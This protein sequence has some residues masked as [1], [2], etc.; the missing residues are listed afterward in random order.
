MRKLNLG[1]GCDY[2]EGFINLDINKEVKADI[3][4][5][6]NKGLPFKDNYFDYIFSCHAIEH[7]KD[8]FGVMD[9][10][11]RVCKDKAIIEIYVP[12]FTSILAMKYTQHNFYFGIDSFISMAEE[13]DRSKERYNKARFKILKQ[14]LHLIHNSVSHTSKRYVKYFRIL[15]VFNPLF[16][17]CWLWQLIMERVFFIG[18]D[19]IYYKLEVIKNQ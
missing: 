13:P 12:H 8:F 19:E 6:I 15:N 2:K 10:I 5:D 4:A 17:I 18:F 1:S 7:T 11:W 16:N 14:E 3:Y 9:D